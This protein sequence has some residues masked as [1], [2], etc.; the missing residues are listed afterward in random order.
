MTRPP[1]AYLTNAQVAE[2]ATHYKAIF[3]LDYTPAKS[4]VLDALNLPSKVGNRLA[5]ALELGNQTL[6]NLAE[7]MAEV[8]RLE[9]ELVVCRQRVLRLEKR[10]KVKAHPAR[11]VTEDE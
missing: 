4:Q 8:E 7:A 9:N 1:T 2:I 10:L 11:R 6:E 5:S 3:A